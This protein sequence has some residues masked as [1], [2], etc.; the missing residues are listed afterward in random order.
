MIPKMCFVKNAL[1]IVN[2]THEVFLVEG[3]INEA[4]DGTFV[5]YIGNGLVK[6][7]DFFSS[8]AAY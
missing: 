8:G 3:V 4:V 6:S 5:K 2:T 1:A 7:F